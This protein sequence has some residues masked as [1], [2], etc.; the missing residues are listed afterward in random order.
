MR[1]K[2][3]ENEKRG[4]IESSMRAAERR[5]RGLDLKKKQIQRQK[6]KENNFCNNRKAIVTT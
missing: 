5:L 4:A 3:K 1:K 2:R 6:R